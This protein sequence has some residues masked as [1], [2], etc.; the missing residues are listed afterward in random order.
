MAADSDADHPVARVKKVTHVQK[1]RQ[2]VYFFLPLM[3]VILFF[4][5]KHVNYGEKLKS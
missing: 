2:Y 1:N 3:R 4:A 5:L